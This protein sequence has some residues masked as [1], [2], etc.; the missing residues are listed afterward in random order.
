MHLEFDDFGEYY[1]EE[2]EEFDS[3]SENMENGTDIYKKGE[4][5]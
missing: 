2:F 3:D 4:I 1:V 5:A